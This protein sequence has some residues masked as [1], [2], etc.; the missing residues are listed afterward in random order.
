MLEISFIIPLQARGKSADKSGVNG[1]TARTQE[2]GRHRSQSRGMPFKGQPRWERVWPD[3]D[4][5]VLLT[6]EMSGTFLNAHRA[7]RK[8]KGRKPGI[9]KGLCGA[10]FL[11]HFFQLLER[12]DS[13]AYSSGATEQGQLWRVKQLF[14]SLFP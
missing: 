1:T 6:T 14:G 12:G 3:R 7:A 11:G 8:V 9:N 2:V 5:A 4:L 10:A 13:H